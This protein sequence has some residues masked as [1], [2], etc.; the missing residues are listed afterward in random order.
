MGLTSTIKELVIKI[1]DKNEH[2]A[3]LY[4][5]IKYASSRVLGA[6]L[7]EKRYAKWFYHLYTGMKLDLD[8]PQLF[9]E[10]LWWLKLNYH[11]PLMTTCSDKSAVREYVKE[12]GY[13]DILIPQFDLFSSV[14]ELDLSKYHEEVIVKCTHNSGGHLI[15]NPEKP[16]SAKEIK[17]KK[18]KLKFI[19]KHNAFYLSREW[20]YKDIPP[21]LI[22]EKIMRDG[23]A[24]PCDYKIFCFNGKARLVEYVIG[25]DSVQKYVNY[26]DVDFNK[27]DMHT[28]KPFEPNSDVA[29][30][31]PK[32]YDRM[33]EIAEKLSAPFPHCRVDLYNVDGHIYFGEM[34]FYNVGGCELWSPDTLQHDFGKEIDINSLK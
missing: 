32:N 19:L 29:Y 8:N 17:Q 14:D 27:I 10:K 25:R 2:G 26:Y 4:Y 3:M 23:D 16:L 1:G 18:K 7:G 9:N 15:Y 12:Q 20:N 24:L 21:R 13:E 34:T 22:V 5:H 31:K 33:I 11:N 30:E 6:I 28:A